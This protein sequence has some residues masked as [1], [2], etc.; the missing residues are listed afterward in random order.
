VPWRGPQTP[1]EFPTLGFQVAD[2]IEAKC[3]IP[4]GLHV[5]DPFLLTDEMLNFLLH[6]YRVDPDTGRFFYDRGSQLVRPQKWGKGPFSAA[7]VCA[8]ADPEGPVLFDGW[9]S[10]GEPVGRPWP[11]PH[12]QITAVSEDQTANV[13]RALLPMI[14][15][16]DIAAD[17]PD[18]GKT[19]INLPSGGLIEPVTAAALSRLGQ[20]T[21]FAVQDQTE[22]WYRTNGGRALA[23]NQ[24]RGIAGMGGRWVETPNAWD[25]V[26]DSVAQI[27]RQEPGVYHDDVEPGSGSVRN[28]ADRKRML[29]RVYGDSA[30]KS[31]PDA[32]WEPWVDLDRIDSEIV[33]LLEHDAAQAERWFLN[34][35]MAGESAAFDIDAYIA[36]AD[37]HEVDDRSLIA[38]GVDGA[39]FRDALAVEATDV[40]TGYQWTLGLW[41]RPNNAAPDYE[42]PF[43]EVDAVMVE[44][45][46]RF[47]PWRAYVDPQYIELLLD[48]WQGRWGDKRVI[49]WTTNRDRQIAWAVRNYTTAVGAG[50][51]AHDG[52]PRA[53]EHVRNARKK[54]VNVF[55]DEHQQMHTIS[56][57]RRGSKL[58]MDAAMAKVLSWECRGDAIADGALAKQPS[59]ALVFH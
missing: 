46:R 15:K 6:H 10:A 58:K 43:D 26:E 48:R 54:K 53:T 4:D 44:A 52:H 19:R 35:K 17:I 23:D 50:D 45:F 31:R 5:G 28:R 12:I 14:E 33:A 51:L 3:A 29:K 36:L 34:R 20:R 47:N 59:R 30:S 25:P 38:I 2:L 24:R 49:A 56:K 42:H 13:Y 37:P 7:M 16:G 18:T 41:E 11:T 32:E 8:E 21:T 22:S 40:L 55:D 27:T 1:G 9:D 39:R 57:D